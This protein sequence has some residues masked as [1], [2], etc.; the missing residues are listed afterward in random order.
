MTD[1]PK[2]F[3]YNWCQGGIAIR[4]A[5]YRLLAMISYPWPGLGGEVQQRDMIKVAKLLGAVKLED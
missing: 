5:K 2:P 1:Y 4:D 3:T